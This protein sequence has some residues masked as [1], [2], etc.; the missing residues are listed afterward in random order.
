MWFYFTTLPRLALKSRATFST[1]HK[2]EL[3]QS[4]F[5]Q[6]LPGLWSAETSDSGFLEDHNNRFFL[7]LPATCSLERAKLYRFSRSRPMPV[8]PRAS[9]GQFSN[10]PSFLLFLPYQRPFVLPR[11]GVPLMHRYRPETKRNKLVL[12]LLPSQ[13]KLRRLLITTEELLSGDGRLK[14][15]KHLH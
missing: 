13:N 7:S 6:L 12:L 10:F 4:D 5:F 1:K 3:N 8:F 2:K 14:V 9:A 15:G 11:G